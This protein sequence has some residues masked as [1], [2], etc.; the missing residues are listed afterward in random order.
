MK[1]EL[2]AALKNVLAALDFPDTSIVIQQP[3]N[4]EHGDFSSNLAMQLAPILG[5]NP[6]DIAQSI[7]NKLEIDFP[8]L[9]AAATIAG[10][11]F[12][13]IH[14]QKDQIISQLKTILKKN[15][16]FGCSDIGDGKKAL[17]EFVSAN[18]TGPL[19]VGH[20]RGAILGDVV[21][22]I[23]EW[24]GYEVE[25]EY[26]YN[27]AGLQM[28]RLGQSVQARCLE[29]MGKPA[30][31]PEE[32]YEGEY[33]I[34][35]ARNLIGEK[36]DSLQNLDNL[37]T[38]IEAAE[39]TIFQDIKNTM[40]KIC[41]KFDRYFNEQSLYESGSLKTVLAELQK[42]D[43]IFDESGATWF[44]ASAVGLEQDRV[45]IKST[46]EPT[47][48]L[49]DMAYHR[50]KFERGYDIMVD[51][52]GADHKDA[53]PDVLA[54]VEQLGYNPDKVIV[55]IHQ[56]VTLTKNGEP[57]KMSTRK[58]QYVTLDELIEEVG[59]DVVRYFFL[60]RGMRTHL[61]FDLDLA[62]DE[63]DENPVYYLQYAHARLCNI[64]KHA[65]SIGYELNESADLT[66][67]TLESELQLIKNLMEFPTIMERAHSS[68]EPQSIANYLQE[69]AGQFHRYY[70]K[71]RIVTNDQAKTSARLILVRVLQIVLCN[72]LKILGIR[73]PERM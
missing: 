56:F 23:L 68:L 18:P 44:R 42:K 28:Q 19:T 57:V 25:R 58:A 1:S 32:G 73:A 29:L 40:E 66:P 39:K 31:F 14:I 2:T 12:I 13:N 53:Y 37:A 60:M 21:S 33:I 17:V 34:D 61:N 67:L 11:G 35:I 62:K 64:I 36:G 9:V 59:V 70:A 22:N 27:D 65:I 3:K 50:D 7:A 26:Y 71:E 5:D 69:L 48:R 16:K 52:L 55:L 30:E 41:L 63:S 20:G 47:Y 49:P 45:M 38:F 46:G 54:G 24:N 4:S 51:V 6:H 72:G 15:T 8:Q 10:P 43:L